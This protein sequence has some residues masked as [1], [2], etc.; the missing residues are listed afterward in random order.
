MYVLRYTAIVTIFLFNTLFTIPWLGITWLCF[1]QVTSVRSV[2]EANSPSTPAKW[3]FKYAVVQL[4][5]IVIN[6]IAWGLVLSP[7]AAT[8]SIDELPICTMIP[9]FVQSSVEIS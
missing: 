4:W 3:M 7:R 9:T 1:V 8:F 2:A 5:P 6:T